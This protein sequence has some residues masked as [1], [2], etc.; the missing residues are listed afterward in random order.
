[1][2]AFF[3]GIRGEIVYIELLNEGTSVWRPASALQVGPRA[4]VV[5][6]PQNYYTHPE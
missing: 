2:D 5:L 3:Q 4:Y 6:L 1:M